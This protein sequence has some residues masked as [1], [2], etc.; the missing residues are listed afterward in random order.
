[1]HPK[2]PPW[3][4]NLTYWMQKFILGRK[5]NFETKNLHFFEFF[6]KNL[7]FF[8][9]HQHLLRINMCYTTCTKRVAHKRRDSEPVEIFLRINIC[10]KRVAHKRRDSEPVESFFYA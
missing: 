9:T 10:T 5:I 2:P 4:P 6:S 3:D 8:F 7:V 1:M